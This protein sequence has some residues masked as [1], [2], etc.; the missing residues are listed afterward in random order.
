MSPRKIQAPGTSSTGTSAP[1]PTRRVPRH[2]RVRPRRVRR[3]GLRTPGHE[4]SPDGQ[5]YA[6]EQVF[7]GEQSNDRYT[8]MVR[9]VQQLMTTKSLSAYVYT[10]STDVEGEYNG[11]LTY[12]R[13]VQKVDTNRLRAARSSAP[14]ATSTPPPVSPWA[15]SVRSR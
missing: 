13:R 3:I 6:Y 4:Y 14:P 10:E 2:P 7:S 12:D 8:G 15:M 1:D 5:F 11:L 9:D